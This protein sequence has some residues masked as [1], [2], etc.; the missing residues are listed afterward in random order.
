LNCCGAASSTWGANLVKDFKKA[1]NNESVKI[2]S[3]NH[4]DSEHQEKT[5]L[6]EES[7]Q[8]NKDP[9]DT[10]P[11]QQPST[12]KYDSR[13]I[14]QMSNDETANSMQQKI[15]KRQNERH[16]PEKVVVV[17]VNENNELD[18]VQGNTKNLT[19]VNIASLGTS[20]LMSSA[21]SK[22]C[23]PSSVLTL[24]VLL[25]NSINP[26]LTP[27]SYTAY[28]IDAFLEYLYA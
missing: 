21:I 12:S 27:S 15:T 10:K 2:K 18:F 3:R 8:D 23:R 17:K 24:F 14:I 26:I 25:E 7:S 20:V 19:F 13:L 5:V 11:Q 22:P 1:L 6:N 9:V 4:I 16:D 28:H